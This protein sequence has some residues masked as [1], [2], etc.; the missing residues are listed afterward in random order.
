SANTRRRTTTDQPVSHQQ[1]I[2]KLSWR[3]GAL[4]TNVQRISA[5]N[6]HQSTLDLAILPNGQDLTDRTTSRPFTV[7][8]TENLQCPSDAISTG[9]WNLQCPSDSISTGAG[10]L[11]CPSERRDCEIFM[12]INSCQ[13]DQCLHS[14]Q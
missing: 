2:D 4:P 7:D 5:H 10:N 9:A 8:W 13:I 6:G 11:Q 1:K 14:Q 12:A 3:H